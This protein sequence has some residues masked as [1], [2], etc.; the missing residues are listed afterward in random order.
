M[1]G[2]ALSVGPLSLALMPLLL[3]LSAWLGVGLARRVGRRDAVDAEPALLRAL[4]IGLLAA[5]LAFVWQWRELYDA[6]LWTVIDIRDGGWDPAIGVAAAVLTAV[7]GVRRQPA[8]R[9]ATVAGFALT[10]TLGLTSAVALKWLEPTRTPMPELRFTALGGGEV[11]LRSFVGR[12]TV[13]NL[14]AT[15][16][17]PCRREMPVLLQAQQARP[18]V[19]FV[20]V[21]QGESADEVQRFL[22]AQG[23]PLH[24]V[25]LDRSSALGAAFQQRGLPTSLFFD[26][27]G[28]LV[29]TRVGELSPAVLAQRLQAL[30]PAPSRG[31]AG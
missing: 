1:T 22:Q 21:N 20:F 4:A 29:S 28:R 9:R 13:V 30:R 3:M 18:D 24:H 19:H 6:H 25:L 17:P 8:L 23:L 31:S 14:W 2:G 5:R 7:Q 27:S 12:P 16:C 26:A 11:A 10:L 15:W